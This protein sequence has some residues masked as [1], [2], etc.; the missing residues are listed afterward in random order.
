[1]YDLAPTAPIAANQP[2]ETAV[3]NKKMRDV[4][5]FFGDKVR[6][7]TEHQNAKLLNRQHNR[8]EYFTNQSSR[9]YHSEPTGAHEKLEKLERPKRVARQA[10][11][12]DNGE[13]CV[14]SST[15]RDA[16]IHSPLRRER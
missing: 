16:P 2:V 9:V 11:E 3:H 1:M 14:R 8:F 15:V 5:I 12:R 10:T 13:C 4:R 7:R 6:H